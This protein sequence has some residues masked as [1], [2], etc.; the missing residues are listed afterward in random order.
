M[1]SPGSVLKKK[2]FETEFDGIF[3]KLLK[4]GQEHLI[5]IFWWSVFVLMVWVLV[6]GGLS[7]QSS[8]SIF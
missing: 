5:R 3:R 1:F 6:G 2:K 8:Q 4:W 7:G